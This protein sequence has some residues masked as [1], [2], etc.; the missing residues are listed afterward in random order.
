[1]N[2]YFPSNTVVV[3]GDPLVIHCK[4]TSN[5]T[6]ILWKFGKLGGVG[7]EPISNK[8]W[9]QKPGFSVNSTEDGQFSLAKE[10]TQLND[11]GTYKCLGL[12]T[13]ESPQIAVAQVAVL[14]K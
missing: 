3:V 1:M 7:E 9:I 13:G 8:T 12:Q 4:A 5:E 6:S 14:R 11:S 10:N 2:G